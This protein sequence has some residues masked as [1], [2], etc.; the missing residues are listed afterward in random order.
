MSELSPR[1]ASE[2]EQCE[3][4][5]ARGLDTF[6]EVGTALLKIRAS[7]LYRLSHETFEEYC[8]E[9]W[10]MS[11]IHAHRLIDAASVAEDLLPTGN[12]PATERQARPLAPFGP[13]HR[14][15]AWTRAVATAPNGKVTAEH[16]KATIDE[17]FPDRGPTNGHANGTLSPPTRRD[18]SAP[19]PGQ[20][21][22]LRDD[23]EEPDDITFD[24]PE[25]D[26]GF[27]RSVRKVL[28]LVIAVENYGLA[29]LAASWSDRER[30][31]IAYRLTNLHAKI[32]AWIDYLNRKD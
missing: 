28:G 14:R 26:Q 1:E 29:R 12:T 17:M 20:M 25:E 23:E 2:L 27:R 11:R 21:S 30:R 9:R 19:L 22:F 31:A 8:R 6:V 3:A 32:G 7:K 5:I 4:V 10:G 16:V 13:D 24:A 18:P 15:Q